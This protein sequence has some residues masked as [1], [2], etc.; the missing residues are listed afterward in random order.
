METNMNNLR[1]LLAM[2]IAMMLCVSMMSCGDSDSSEDDRSILQNLKSH[3]WSTYDTSFDTWSD[4]MSQTS[5]LWTIY[6]SSDTEGVIHWNSTE[7]D[8]YFGTSHDEGH[9][10]FT[11]TLSDGKVYLYLE[12]NNEWE[13]KYY[14]SYMMW[15][16]DMFTAKE[17]TSSDY[18]YLQDHALG[19]HGTEGTI[20]ADMIFETSIFSTYDCSENN[21][22]ATSGWYVYNID[23]RVGATLDAYKKG[24]T[25]MRVTFWSS[26]A[27]YARFQTSE[28][29]KKI[30]NEYTVTSSDLT[31]F[32]RIMMWSMDSSITV[33][34]K[35]DYYNSKDK[36]WYTFRE[37]TSSF[38]M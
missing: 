6:F 24:V 10:G 25:R 31:Y 17:M 23:Y 18:S 28:Y 30:T 3:K 29:G 9:I 20:N 2:M 32:D 15:G 16:D 19:Y 4:E 36:S 1:N 11:Y 33:N 38:N 35:I 7:R 37:V 27:A 34:F 21:E 26:N 5:Q 22:S 12:T 14:G 8:T 13:L